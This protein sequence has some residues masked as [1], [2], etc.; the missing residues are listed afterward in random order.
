MHFQALS[1]CSVFYNFKNFEIFATANIRLHQIGEIPGIF[2][3]NAHFI[4]VSVPPLRLLSRLQRVG[5]VVH[6]WR[7]SYTFLFGEAWP[8]LSED[9][10]SFTR[11]WF[12]WSRFS[13]AVP[14]WGITIRALLRLVICFIIIIITYF[15]RL[16]NFKCGK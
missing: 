10:K 9:Y 12:S 8:T 2:V 3:E 4:D 7:V 16:K 5:V 11:F 13:N 14:K 1:Y 15:N 6:I